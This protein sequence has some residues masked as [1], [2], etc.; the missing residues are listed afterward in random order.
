MSLLTTE[1]VTAWVPQDAGAEGLTADAIAQAEGLAN[2][3][4]DRTLESASYDEYIS[5]PTGTVDLNL[6]EYPVTAVEAVTESPRDGGSALTENT[7]YY[8]NEAAGIITRVG[9]AW[10]GGRESVRAQYTAGYTSATMPPM[11]KT[12]LLQLVAWRL[13]FRGAAGTTNESQDGYS[14]AIEPLTLGVPNSIYT[15]LKQFRRRNV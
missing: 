11:L 2:G 5:S 12:A 8:V 4:C 1:D 7:D 9:S 14:R 13:E 15:M 3:A 6:R 10:A